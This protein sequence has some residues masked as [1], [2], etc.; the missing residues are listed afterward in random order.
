MRYV[1]EGFGI[2]IAVIVAS[3]LYALYTLA[4]ILV[5]SG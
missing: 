4:S 3:M 5:G 2:V 1:D